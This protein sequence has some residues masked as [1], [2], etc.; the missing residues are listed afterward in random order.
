M[1]LTRTILSN[2]AKKSLTRIYNEINK[3]IYGYGVTQIRISLDDGVISIYVKHQRVPALKSLE[4]RYGQMK[5]AVDYALHSEFKLRFKPRV[6][7]E[8]GL[9]AAAILRDYDPDTEWA[10]TVILTE[11]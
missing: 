2:D 8:F 10:V 6:E 4:E 3:E 5:Q 1:S 9:K 11:S 7:E